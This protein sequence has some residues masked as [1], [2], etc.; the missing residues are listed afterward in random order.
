MSIGSIESSVNFKFSWHRKL[1]AGSAHRSNTVFARGTKTQWSK[2]AFMW[3]PNST[4]HET[5][6]HHEGVFAQ[7]SSPGTK[8]RQ[9]VAMDASVRALFARS[10]AGGDEG[11]TADGASVNALAL[12]H[13]VGAIAVVAA[14]DPSSGSG[15]GP[16]TSTEAPAI[17]L[18]A[19]LPVAVAGSGAPSVSAYGPQGHAPSHA[20]GPYDRRVISRLTLSSEVQFDSDDDMEWHPIRHSGYIR[21]FWKNVQRKSA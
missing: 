13:P 17:P 4:V 14:A 8:K 12:T 11:P 5:C 20:D 9:C 3:T 1:A 19:D 2:V 18:T 21:D 15:G 7:T 16:A 10:E 6:W